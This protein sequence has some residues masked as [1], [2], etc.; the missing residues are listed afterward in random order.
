MRVLLFAGLKESCG[1]ATLEVEATAPLT[2]SELRAAAE[3]ACP[4]LAGRTFR[5][6]VDSSYAQ[7]AD[8]VPEGAEVA[9]LPPVSGG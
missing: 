8:S 7:D 4:A 5:V 3:R 6:A 1:G 2:V 9:F